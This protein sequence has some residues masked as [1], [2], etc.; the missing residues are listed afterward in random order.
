MEQVGNE[1]FRKIK[2]DVRILQGNAP[3]RLSLTGVWIKSRRKNEK[4][5]KIIITNFEKSK[6][7][8]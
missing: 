5:E 6:N 3:D 2:I 4:V 1:R 8:K 7:L